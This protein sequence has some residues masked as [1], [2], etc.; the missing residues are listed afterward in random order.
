MEE[1]R[2]FFKKLDEKTK[3]TL[4]KV[5]LMRQPLKNSEKSLLTG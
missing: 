3:V 4:N 2:R 1:M 5:F